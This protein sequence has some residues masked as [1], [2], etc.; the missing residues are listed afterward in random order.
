M[1]FAIRK[2]QAIKYIGKIKNVTLVGE[3]HCMLRKP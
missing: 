1:G 2:Y 3:L